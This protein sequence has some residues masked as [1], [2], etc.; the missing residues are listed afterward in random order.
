MPLPIFVD[1]SAWIAVADSSESS[2]TAVIPIYKQLLKSASRL[3]TTDLVIAET[4]ILLLRRMGADAANLFLDSANHS[5]SIEIVFLDQEM[6]LTAKKVLEKLSDQDLSFTDAA[7][8]AIMKS[9]KIRTAF[10]LDKHFAIAGF[11]TLPEK[12]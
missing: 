8:F 3:I 7:S 5:P 1:T 11:R 12:S 10:T 9:R 2:H 4:Q 6:E